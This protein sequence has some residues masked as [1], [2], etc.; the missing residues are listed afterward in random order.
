MT[1]NNGVPT[2]TLQPTGMAQDKAV[3][4]QAARTL[5]TPGAAQAAAETVREMD[6]SM[7]TEAEKRAI[8]DFAGQIDL[9]NTDHV[10]L[11]GADAQKKIA[12][13]SDSALATVRTNDTGEVGDMLVNLVNEIRGFGEA[14]EK[15]KGIAGLFWNAKK[16]V[17]DMQTRYENVEA[18]VDT[19]AASL[20]Q[21]QVQLL[22]DVAMFNKL[23]DMNTQY[24]KELTMYIL[25]GE[26]RLAQVRQG[27]LQELLSKAA[28]TGD[29]MD[30]QRAND[31]AANC[32]RFEKKLHDLKLTRQV[33]LQ[34]APQIRLLQNNDSL[35]VER[36]QS[37]L[38][39]TLPLWKSQIL[40]ALGMHRSQEALRAQTAVSD[41][42]N[43]LLKKNAEALR[44]GTVETAQEAERGIIDLQT[45][46][47]T[48][49]S[50]IDTINEVMRI[51]DEG[52]AKRI[53]AEKQ[54]V[55]MEDELKRKL[56]E[57]RQ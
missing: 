11:Y 2:L 36:I 1:Q 26:R 44:M 41:M 4:E 34:M 22:K 32:D 54:L 33:A 37:T 12:D 30:A 53:E 27:T 7:L 47:E 48:N 45:L 57:L 8:E 40:I 51:Q 42:T 18:N 29:A 49:Q 17:S 13:F 20:E 10:L 52:R 28:Q 23:Y 5:E 25:A 15:P 46:V 19:I 31:M 39:N 55:T 24:F 38:S 35:L 21:H 43:E 16:A 14:A 9:N 56:L 3:L 6:A 50:L